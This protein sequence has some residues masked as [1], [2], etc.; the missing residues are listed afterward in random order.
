MCKLRV[1]QCFIWFNLLCCVQWVHAFQQDTRAAFRYPITE[2]HTTIKVDGIVD[3]GEWE[4]YV[5]IDTFVQ[6]R[7]Q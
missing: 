6:S 5:L 7:P 2:K 4:D 1:Y 3:K